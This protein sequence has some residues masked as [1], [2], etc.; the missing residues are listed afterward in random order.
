MTGNIFQQSADA[1]SGAG[2]ALA[3]TVQPG[4]I[5][6]SMN[7]Y[8]NQYLAG[9]LN[10]ALARNREEMN[11]TLSGIGGQASQLGAFGGSRQAVLE[12]QTIGQYGKNADELTASL[13]AQGYDN[14]AALAM[15]E[16]GLMQSG[17]GGLMNLGNSGFN[18]G[19]QANAGQAAAGGKQQGLLQGLL[20]GAAGQ[21]DGYTNAPTQT[22]STLLA[23]L[24]GNPL[25]G[26]TSSTSTFKPGLFNYLSMGA[27]MAGAG[28]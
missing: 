16:L 15:Q 26:N 27:G 19:Q 10:P 25:A 17:A 20:S 14:S 2:T 28:K 8:F 3:T 7:G 24:S 4:A 6:N 21:F 23:A 11:T 5:G 22:L 13:M 12:G 18:M 1:M 9:V